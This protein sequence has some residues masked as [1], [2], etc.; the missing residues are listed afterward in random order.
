[1]VKP[2][3]LIQRLVLDEEMVRLEIKLVAAI[4]VP[5]VF[6]DRNV[7]QVASWLER[8]GIHSLGMF[9]KRHRWNGK[10]LTNMDDAELRL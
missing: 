7:E 1:M 10:K 5:P 6:A 4:D 8:V 9:A 2:G 3:D